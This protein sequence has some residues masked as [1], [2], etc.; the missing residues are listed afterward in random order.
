MYVKRKIKSHYDR[1][2][3]C[4]V[5]QAIERREV[6]E[7]ELIEFLAEFPRVLKPDLRNN[8]SSTLTI[9]KEYFASRCFCGEQEEHRSERFQLRQSVEK[10][11][12]IL[13]EKRLHNPVK[14]ESFFKGKA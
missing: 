8:K 1:S 6:L 7:T 10:D 11:S 4:H 3:T 5:V 14:H 2:S 12:R 9:L 13:L